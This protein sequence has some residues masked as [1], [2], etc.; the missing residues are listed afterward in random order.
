LLACLTEAKPP[1]GVLILKLPGRVFILIVMAEKTGYRKVSI[2][3]VEHIAEIQA[4]IDYGIDVTM[5]IDNMHRS[6]S[7]RIRRHQAALE[8][9]EKLHKARRV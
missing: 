6:P 8:I 7:E 3:D 4:A 9:F 1:V 5:L 2:K